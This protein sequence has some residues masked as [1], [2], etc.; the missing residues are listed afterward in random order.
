MK[1]NKLRKIRKSQYISPFGVG[2]ILD[3]GNESFI[4]RDISQWRQG[5]G[6]IIRL[7]RLETRLCVKEFRMPPI[8]K[9]FWDKNPAKLPYQRFP[10]WLFCPSCRKL[11]RW[12]IK[13][14]SLGNL[15]KCKNDRCSGSKVLVPMRFVMACEDGHLADVPWDRWVHS[16][17]NIEDGN[18][19]LRTNLKFVSNPKAGGGLASLVIRCDA[20][21]K[22]KSL[23]GITGENVAV[24]MGV[25]CLGKQPWE[26]VNALE[27]KTC[28]N[29]KPRVMQRGASN[30]YFP[31]TISALDIPLGHVDPVQNEMEQEIR[32]HGFFQTIVKKL[33]SSTGDAA[34]AMVKMLAQ[35]VAGDVGCDAQVVLDLAKGIEVTGDELLP[36]IVVDEGE[37]LREEWPILINPPKEYT[38][39]DV[40]VAEEEFFKSTDETFGLNRLFDKLILVRRLREVR[41]LRGFNRIVPK[42]DNF[43]HADLEKK[44]PW[45]PA[46]EVFGEGIF[47]SFSEEAIESWIASNKG[48][49]SSRINVM[50]KRYD[51]KQ[52][53]FLPDPTP[54][55]VLLHTFSHLLM[56]QLSFECGY[57]SS[58]LRER[59]YSAEANGDTQSMAGV[60]IYTA[61]SDSEGA[62]GGLVRQGNKDRFIPTVL[63]ALERGMWCSADPVCKELP[64]Q[65]MMG[66][67]R[68]ACHSCALV[69]ETSCISNNMLLDRML[70]LGNNE[71]YGDFGFF[72][73]VISEFL[74]GAT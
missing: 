70:V 24:L 74:L 50:K 73:T 45:L 44:I 27:E 10:L 60:L 26:Y 4:A 7:K 28:C 8:P 43:V 58:S 2:A 71:K 16:G 39:S 56:R 25:K 5:S 18:C 15:P 9:G 32:S 69:S 67:N 14:E 57:S 19:T 12:T 54:R 53:H 68:A 61:D 38:A 62:L 1:G 72:N 55:F 36:S 48:A 33:A 49:L 41:V 13:D 31:K 30:L 51:D 3:I 35:E 22:K 29:E 34:Q 47:M 21:G 65:G 63:T 52:L 40:F 59:I 17:R 46:T 37:V 64:G 6:E 23:A 20:C 42:D 66:L 11:V